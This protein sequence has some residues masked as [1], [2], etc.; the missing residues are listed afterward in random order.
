MTFPPMEDPNNL[1]M[2]QIVL[3]ASQTAGPNNRL[4]AALKNIKEL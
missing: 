1:M 4:S 2:N 3:K